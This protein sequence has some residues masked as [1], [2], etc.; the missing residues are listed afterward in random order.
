MSTLTDRLRDDIQATR[1][2]ISRIEGQQE[3]AQVQLEQLQ[4][5]AKKLGFSDDVTKMRQEVT[6][7]ETDV[8]TALKSVQEEVASLGLDANAGQ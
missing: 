6:T 1:A 3:T 4:K 7:M 8:T 2:D 5:E